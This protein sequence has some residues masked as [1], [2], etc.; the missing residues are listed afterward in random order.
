MR[1]TILRNSLVV[2]SVLFVGCSTQNFSKKI[3]TADVDLLKEESL[4][5]YNTN[6]LETMDGFYLQGTARMSPEKVYKGHGHFRSG[7]A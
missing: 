5:R 2:I 4:M 7:N 6:R 3:E 1:T